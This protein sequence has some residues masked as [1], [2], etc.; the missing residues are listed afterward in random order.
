M[1]LTARGPSA[2]AAESDSSDDEQC[3]FPVSR[4]GFL[5]TGFPATKPPV[6]KPQGV[7]PPSWAAMKKIEDRILERVEEALSEMRAGVSRTDAKVNDS[8]VP[9][10][11]NFEACLERIDAKVDRVEE[12]VPSVR[13]CES[14]VER[15]D[16]RVSQLQN[17][18]MEQVDVKAKLESV[19][20]QQADLRSKL[21][22]FLKSLSLEQAQMKA[23]IHTIEVEDR[24]SERAAVDLQ[25]LSEQVESL[26]EEL[27]SIGQSH[28]ELRMEQMD[29]KTKLNDLADVSF[30]AV[31]V[32]NEN[33]NEELHEQ[34]SGLEQEIEM[35]ARDHNVLATTHF[36]GLQH[37]V[38][39]CLEERDADLRQEMS[40]MHEAV[41]LGQQGFQTT[42]THIEQLQ[43]SMRKLAENTSSSAPA[44]LSSAPAHAAV[45]AASFSGSAMHDDLCGKLGK[46]GRSLRAPGADLALSPGGFAYSTKSHFLGAKGDLRPALGAS[47]G[48][49][50]FA[51]PS[52]N[53]KRNLMSC[54]SLPGLQAGLV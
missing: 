53:P 40:S 14:A 17:V 4:M 3:G 26:E 20:A 18:A 10:L 32:D 33:D 36:V 19:Q 15:N 54:R 2:A 52:W 1:M 27:A 44:E 37:E 50:L 22:F 28:G 51:Q 8:V 24:S 29:M 34:I 23:R 11:Q 39:H 9:M 43:D 16:V 30:S 41:M 12:M 45:A 48:A 31:D 35:L 5:S 7:P 6:T 13:R 38:H 47:G 21:E 46:E 25:M 49:A 42:L